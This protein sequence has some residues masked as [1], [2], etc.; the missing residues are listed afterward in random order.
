MQT[1]V[2]RSADLRRHAHAPAIA[3]AIEVRDGESESVQ[4]GV[5][6][7]PRNEVVLLSRVRIGSL[8]F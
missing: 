4:Y 6:T 1:L 3:I 5:R 2:F 7:V 8:Y